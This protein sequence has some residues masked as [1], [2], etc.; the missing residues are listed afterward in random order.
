MSEIGLKRVLR[1]T[2]VVAVVASQLIAWSGAKAQEIKPG[3]ERV[4]PD[5]AGCQVEARTLDGLKAVFVGATPVAE[6]APPAS[7]T[8]P[9]GS[10]VDAVTATN[11]VAT[12]HEAF[13]CLNAPDFM[14]FFALLT[15]RAIVTAFPW[16]A[17]MVANADELSDLY[18]PTEMPVDQWQTLLAVAG[19]SR[20][21]DGR[22]GASIAFIDP[23]SDAE[24]ADSLYLIFVRD[25]DRWLI[26]EVFDF[27]VS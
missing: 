26:D 20:L 23:V 19:I 17:E 16:I 25:G 4:T 22:V 3:T 9:T 7:V 6:M 12:V 13:A 10:P 2:L 21:N 5:P 24:G 27:S 8:I 1:V 18:L 11:V 15:D 14:R